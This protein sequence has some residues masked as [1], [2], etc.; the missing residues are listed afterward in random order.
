KEYHIDGARYDEVTV[1]DSH[2]GTDFCRD[3]TETVRYARPEA[4][5]IAE[6][7]GG[8]RALPGAPPQS[9]GLGFDAAIDDRLRNQLRTAL[10]QACGGGDA[11]VNLDHVRDALYP[12]PA[13]PAAC[14]SV[15]HLENHDIVLGR[16]GKQNT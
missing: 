3:L 13:Y 14:R 15:Q 10:A 2:G 9:G 11:Q 16:G 1:I 12:P 5:H 8:A 7:W 4:V 6:N